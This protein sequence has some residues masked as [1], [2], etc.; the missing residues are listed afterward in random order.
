MAANHN[1]CKRE[2]VSALL[3]FYHDL[4]MLVHYSSDTDRSTAVDLSSTVVLNPQ[5]LIDMFTQIA[6]ASPPKEKVIN[7]PLICL[8]VLLIYSPKYPTFRPFVSLLGPLKQTVLY[9]SL[10]PSRKKHTHSASHSSFKG[11]DYS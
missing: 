7:I 5:W 1:I 3:Q 4:G 6:A 8:Y 11:K 10:M 2:E 9:Y